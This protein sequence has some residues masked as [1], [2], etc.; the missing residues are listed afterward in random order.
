MVFVINEI[1]KITGRGKMLLGEVQN[2]PIAVGEVLSLLDDGG[3]KLQDV[4]I[5]SIDKF[6]ETV[7]IAEV[8][9]HVALM[10]E[11]SPNCQCQ[12]G[13]TL[14]K[15]SGQSVSSQLKVTDIIALQDMLYN[16]T[17]SEEKYELQKKELF[18][19]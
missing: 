11:D 3:N 14:A 13:M 10:V 2:K 12:K 1:M 4:A 7:S 15:E 19:D 8:G 9:E 5:R 16:G 6:R 18:G 17:I